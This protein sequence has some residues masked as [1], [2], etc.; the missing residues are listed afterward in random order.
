MRAH[1]V[2]RPGPRFFTRGGPAAD[3]CVDP[4]PARTA[5]GNWALPERALPPDMTVFWVRGS[6]AVEPLAV[7]ATDAALRVVRDHLLVRI[8][9]PPTGTTWTPPLPVQ[10]CFW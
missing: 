3:P 10:V 7:P 1:G 5:D 8:V 2:R 9:L 4:A 6:G